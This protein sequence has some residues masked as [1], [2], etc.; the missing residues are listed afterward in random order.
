MAKILIIDDDPDFVLAVRMPLEAAGFEV[1]E[2]SA[3]EEGIEKVL[4]VQPDLVILDVMM[5]TGY[6]G[7]ETARVIREEHGLKE[8][9]IVMLTSL[10]EKRQVPYRFAPDENYLPVDVFLDKPIEPDALVDT[11]N[12]VL[13]ERREEPKHPL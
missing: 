10:H 13:G 12:E 9:P 1:D 3:A 8:L 11:I 7:F 6:E 4:S 2:A 5:P